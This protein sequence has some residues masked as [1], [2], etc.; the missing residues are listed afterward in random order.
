MPERCRDPSFDNAQTYNTM[1]RSS[2]SWTTLG[3]VFEKIMTSYSWRHLVI[4]SDQNASIS[5]CVF[6][7]TSIQSWL[8]TPDAVAANFSVYVTPMDDNPSDSTIMY[9]LDTVYRRTRGK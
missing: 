5:R 6:G 3:Q 4:L 2:G 1:M 8:S 7:A 9:Y